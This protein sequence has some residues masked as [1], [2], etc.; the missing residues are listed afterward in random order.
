MGK[1]CIWLAHG[2]CK[3]RHDTCCTDCCPFSTCCPTHNAYMSTSQHWR[4]SLLD[5]WSIPGVPMKTWTSLARRVCIPPWHDSGQ[6][7]IT[8]QNH[9]SSACWPA[10]SIGLLQRSGIRQP[11]VRCSGTAVSL[12]VSSGRTTCSARRFGCTQWRSTVV[13]HLCRGPAQAL[14]CLACC[15]LNGLEVYV[16]GYYVVWLQIFPNDWWVKWRHQLDSDS[17][18]SAQHGQ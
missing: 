11:A 2:H 14:D 15:A 17:H 18:D 3:Y 1:A 8:C 10:C 6:V 7:H 12:S 5:M 4:M 13:R 16:S 9:V